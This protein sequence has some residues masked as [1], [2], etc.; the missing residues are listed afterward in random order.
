M[1]WEGDVD[2]QKLEL[3]GIMNTLALYKYNQ[4]QQ[5]R[6]GLQFIESLA[7][8]LNQFEPDQREVALN[9]IRDRLVFLSDQ[10]MRHLVELLFRDVIRPILRTRV[11]SALGLPA[12][13]VS[14]TEES[15][16]FGTEFKRSL[17]LGLS[18]GARID[19]LRRS[20]GLNNDQVDGSYYLGPPRAQE[21]RSKMGAAFRNVFLIDDFYGSGKSVIRWEKDERWLANYED[22]ATPAGRLPKFLSLIGEADFEGVFD[23]GVALHICLYSATE[24]ALLHIRKAID[25]YPNPPWNQKPAVH[26]A[27]IISDRSRLI[28]GLRDND[29]DA[30]LHEKYKADL[31]MNE[32]RRVGGDQIVHGFS[33]CGL[34]LVF[35]HNAPNNSVYLL[36]ETLEPY[37]ALF[38]RVDRHKAGI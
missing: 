31:L 4:Y 14:A 23:E 17:F 6:P 26:A 37:V 16:E 19:E 18:D 22:G 29:F 33:D 34:S 9:F 5:Y 21:M 24:Q 11:S 25:E 13:R 10:E 32:H 35:A 38:P 15:P 36:W 27:L 7:I 8:W 20:G 30:I 28:C 2:P 12:Y 1:G 3:V